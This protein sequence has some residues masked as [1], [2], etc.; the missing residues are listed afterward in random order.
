MPANGSLAID[1][2]V[3]IAF[4]YG[5]PAVRQQFAEAEQVFLSIVVLGEL[6]FGATR[7]GRVEHNLRQIESLAALCQVVDLDVE[8]SRNYGAIKSA[9]RRNGTLIPDN[10]IWIAASA[11]CLDVALATRDNH[12]DVVENLTVARW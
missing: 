12:F 2:N 11:M 8:T 3:A 4:L 1:T 7:S 6:Y 9:L 10:D 5:E